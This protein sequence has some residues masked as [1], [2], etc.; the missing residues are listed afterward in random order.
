MSMA[1]ARAPAALAASILAKMVSRSQG[2][3]VGIPLP[4][5]RPMDSAAAAK[6]WG[7]VPS[8]VKAAMP[9]W[10]QAGIR[11]SLYSKSVNLSP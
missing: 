8:P 5:L 7:S 3:T 10:A 6:T 1:K 11:M 9:D 4:P 2:L